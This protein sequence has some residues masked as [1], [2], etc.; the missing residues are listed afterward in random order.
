MAITYRGEGRAKPWQVYWRNPFTNKKQVAHFATEE[1]AKKEDSLIKHRLRFDRES[2]REVVE[3]KAE[4]KNTRANVFDLGA[5]VP[6]L[7]EREEFFQ[8]IVA[9]A[10]V[11]HEVHSF[12]AWQ[13]ASGRDKQKPYPSGDGRTWTDWHNADNSKGTS[14]CTANSDELERRP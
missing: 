14:I 6:A 3:A 1:E 5:S 9:M 2:F 10:N 7:P 13:Y 12:K 4:E 11:Q 8:K